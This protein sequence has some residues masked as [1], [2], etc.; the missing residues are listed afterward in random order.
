MI[1]CKLSLPEGVYDR[2]YL[3]AMNRKPKSTASAIAAEIL[4]RNLPRLRI[5]RE[6]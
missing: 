6:G 1:A 2:L 5:E 3:T 4:E